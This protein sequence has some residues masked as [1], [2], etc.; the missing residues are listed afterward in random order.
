[1]AVDYRTYEKRGTSEIVEKKSRFLGDAMRVKTLEEAEAYIA[2]VRKE[3][4]DARH[5]CFA[6]VTGEP[7]TP[8]EIV[9]SSDDGEPSGTAGKPMLEILTGRGLHQCLIVVTRYFGG[10]LLGTGGLVRAYSAAAKEAV[11]DAGMIAVRQGMRFRIR[12][13]YPALGKFQYLFP[14]EGFSIEH[15]EYGADVE[16]SVVTPASECE[17]LVRLVA[18]TTDGTALCEKTGAVTYEE[19]V[20]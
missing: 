11:E 15:I 12:C 18:E 2:Q 20:G 16:L 9:R 14:K 13:T 1:M 3:H 8:D 4:Y 5:H 6:Y 19:Q 10:T 17:K 7:G